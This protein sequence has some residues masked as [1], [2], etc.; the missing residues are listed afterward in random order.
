MSPQRIRI[1]KG[2]F[3]GEQLEVHNSHYALPVIWR[4]FSGAALDGQRRTDATW[5]HRGTSPRGDAAPI[6]WDYLTRWERAGIRTGGTLGIA[7]LGASAI[8]APGATLDGVHYGGTGI[9]CALA[10]WGGHRLADGLLTWRHR[11]DWL[12]PLHVALRPV[13][14][15]PEGTKPG[16]YITLPENFA[17]ITGEMLRIQLPATWVGESSALIAEGQER[18]SQIVIRKL[19]LQDVSASYHVRGRDHYMTMRQAPRPPARVMWADAAVQRMVAKADPDAP[20]LGLTHQARPVAVSLDDE[21]PHILVSAGTGGGKSVIL[22]TIAAQFMA[23]GAKV[24]VLDLKRHSHKWIRG[25]PGVTYCRDVED[26]HETMEWLTLE[27][28]RRNRIVDEWEGDPNDAPVGPRI[29]I[30]LE[31]LNATMGRLKKYWKR[32]KTKED[33]PESPAITGLAD[34]LFMGRAVRMNVIACAQSATANAL[35]GPEMRENFATRIL[36]RY[37]KNAWNMLVPE[38]QPAPSSTRH[39]GRAQVVLG[40]VAHETQIM[41]FTPEEARAFVLSGG[42]WMDPGDELESLPSPSGGVPA[43]RHTGPATTSRHDVTDPPLPGDTRPE[44]HVTATTWADPRDDQD[45]VPRQRGPF[46]IYDGGRAEESTPE[47]EPERELFGFAEA[48]R[49]GIITLSDTPDKTAQ[50]LRTEK[51][52]DPEFPEPDGTK[53]GR[54]AYYAE[55]LQRWARNRPRAAGDE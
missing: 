55:T 5:T 7:G 25:L 11:R 43:V 20:L 31:E 42:V 19:G 24:V 54:P 2:A 48:A 17:Q 4:W 34:V 38:V 28:D 3:G 45:Q 9:G 32:I 46:Q 27:G 21:S 26:I 10:L 33:D 53:N 22:R 8:V 13:L 23:Q 6:W 39:P 51:R 52:R 1:R 18:I 49:A 35:G 41:F 36:A 16:S 37:T 30:L 12:W 29:V 40:G 44:R 15:Y 47:R 14:G 50:I